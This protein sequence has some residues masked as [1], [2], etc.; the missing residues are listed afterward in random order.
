[1]PALSSTFLFDSL[2]HSFEQNSMFE[3]QIAAL[4]RVD[5]DQTLAMSFIVGTGVA[6]K[7]MAMRV[8]LDDGI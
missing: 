8:P 3:A 5:A 2:E 1:M 6:G 7:L 4:R